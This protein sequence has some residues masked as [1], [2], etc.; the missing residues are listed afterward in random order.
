MS[1]CCGGASYCADC[2]DARFVQ[3]VRCLLAFADDHDRP[4]VE[5]LDSVQGEI[6]QGL[7]PE[8]LCPISLLPPHLLSVVVV[9]TAVDRDKLAGGVADLVSSDS[10]RRS[11]GGQVHAVTSSRGCRPTGSSITRRTVV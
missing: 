8:S 6:G 5:A 4:T 2:G 9:D 11:D 3:G 1:W 7:T 10:E